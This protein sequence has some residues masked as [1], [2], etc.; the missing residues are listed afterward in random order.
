[1]AVYTKTEAYHGNAYSHE[2]R[3]PFLVLCRSFVII[4]RSAP[5]IKSKSVYNCTNFPF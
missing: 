3:V 4:A 1:M 5:G 2:G